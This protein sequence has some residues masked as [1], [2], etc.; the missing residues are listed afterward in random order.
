[1]RRTRRAAW[2]LGLLLLF[3]HLLFTHDHLL[4]QSPAAVSGVVVDPSGAPVPD[5]TVRVEG[6]DQPPRELQTAR[7]GSFAVVLQAAATSIRIRVTAAGFAV[8]EQSARAGDNELRIALEPAP[9]FEAVNV[10][11]TRGDVPR[12]DPTSTVTVLSSS[13]LLSQGAATLDDALKTV[14]GFTL[15]R[16]TSSRVSNPTA[17]GVAL[18]GLGGTGASR[19]L[20]LADGLPLNDAFGG[21]VYWDKVPQVAIDRIEVQRGSGSDLYG[22]DAVGGVVQILT[23]RPTRPTLRALGEGGSLGTGRVSMLGGGRSGGLSYMGSGE[24]FTTE[25]YIPVAVEQ[26]A[27]LAARGAVDTKAG[28]T[29]R[30]A[31][32]SAGYQTANGWRFDGRLSVFKEDRKNGTPLVVN[33]TDARMG[34]G[35]VSGGIRGGLL[36]VRVFRGTQDYLQTFSAVAAN[37][38]SE[39]LNRISRVPTT[40]AGI[41]GQW[42]QPWGRHSML[43]G[44]EQRSI[45][46]TTV[47]TPY[48]QGRPQ[49][50]IEAGGHQR[51]GSAFAQ[52]VVEASDRLT[53]VAGA[54]VDGWH[55]ESQETTYNKTLGAFNPRGSVAYRIGDSG[56]SLRGSVY[57][58][59]RAPTLNELYRGFR[60]G[61][62]ETRPNEALRPERLT[63]GDA[64]ILFARS[65]A[66]ARVTGFWNVLDDTITNITLSST[67]QLISKQRANAD[68]MRA[69]GVEVEGEVRVSPSLSITLATAI[70]NSKFTGDTS[71]GGNRV[72]QIPRYNVGLNVRYTRN[73]WTASGQFR[74]TGPQFEDDLNL[75]TLRR[76]ADLDVYGSRHVGGL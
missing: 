74:V 16:R 51:V 35:E 57:R 42:L 30:S 8:A 12:A 72:P 56:V 24:W 20:V 45:D 37:R 28:S 69:A 3:T 70:V 65:G 43:I 58:G 18:R 48:T 29:H 60:S 25:G 7:D 63:G 61:N 41:G 49:A 5:A 67:P 73:E 21:W 40:V 27:G 17:Q 54:H 13:E 64:G 76:A 14:P 46:G 38:G 44:A 2:L 23:V 50:T 11:S 22:A 10:T 34:S 59:F 71:L 52:L 53:F 39:T 1:M 19:S 47:D 15:F 26:D 62:T 55:T 4:A 33:D 31:I 68:K 66:S 32:A 6:S 36:S 9:F 75:F